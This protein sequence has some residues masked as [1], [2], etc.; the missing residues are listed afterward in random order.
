MVV[1]IITDDIVFPKV[2][3]ALN[4]DDYQRYLPGIFQAVVLTDGNKCR[5]VDIDNLVLVST[6]YQCRAGNDNPVFTA[7]MMFLKRKPL[8]RRDL[9]PLDLVTA[10]LVKNQI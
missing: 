4:L 10:A 1:I 5:F 9:D 2:L 7:M 6:G 3:T 8:S